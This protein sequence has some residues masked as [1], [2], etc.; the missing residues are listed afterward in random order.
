MSRVNRL[1]LIDFKYLH[2][3]I[4]RNFWQHSFQI[5]I[6]KSYSGFK[7]FTKQ[8]T[9]GNNYQYKIAYNYIIILMC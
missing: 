5:W 3:R 1:E 9:F 7:E 8:T 6:A 4:K 2:F